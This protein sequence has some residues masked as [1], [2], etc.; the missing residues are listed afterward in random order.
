MA[1]VEGAPPTSAPARRTPSLPLALSLALSL[2]SE[3]LYCKMLRMFIFA[4]IGLGSK[5]A[6]KGPSAVGRDIKA[7]GRR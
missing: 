5:G 1:A 4:V 7:E 6:C 3:R 2:A